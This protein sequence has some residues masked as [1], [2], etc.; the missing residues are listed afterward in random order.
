[1]FIAMMFV[2]K[3]A[4]GL[5]LVIWGE[6]TRHATILCLLSLDLT[7]SECCSYKMFLATV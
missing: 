4:F 3:C 1:M 6:A 7:K 5:V 2:A